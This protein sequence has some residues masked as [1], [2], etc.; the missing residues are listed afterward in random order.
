MLYISSMWRIRKI[1]FQKQPASQKPCS[2]IAC[3][4][5]PIA[6]TPHL[7]WNDLSDSSFHNA[8]LCAHSTP[9]QHNTNKDQSRMICQENETCKKCPYLKLC[10]GG[11]RRWREP[12]TENCDSANLLCEAYEIFFEH[13]WERIEKLGKLILQRY[14][15]PNK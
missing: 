5:N 4:K 7:L 3:F 11:C 10:H 6:C 9:P 2:F 12:V 15:R 13:T 1:V 8:V 14:G